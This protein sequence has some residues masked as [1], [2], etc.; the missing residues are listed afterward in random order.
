MNFCETVNRIVVWNFIENSQFEQFNIDD[1]IIFEKS[2]LSIC[3]TRLAYFYSI[4][5]LVIYIVGRKRKT[6]RERFRNLFEH[7]MVDDITQ[8]WQINESINIL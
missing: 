7:H 2:M 6:K 8:T 4:S 3:E 5:S 1:Q